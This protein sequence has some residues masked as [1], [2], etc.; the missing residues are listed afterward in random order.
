MKSESRKNLT[1]NNF[2]K[3]LN[4]NYSQIS[5]ES[6]YQSQNY[7]KLLSSQI[8]STNLS[9]KNFLNISNKK[10]KK[11]GMFD[12]LN[13]I[14]EEIE[15]IAYDLD[16]V[17]RKNSD[18]D[19]AQLLNMIE[20]DIININNIISQN[21]LS[22]D[23]DKIITFFDIICFILKKNHKKFIENEL[24][25]IYFL[26]IEKLLALFKPLDIN[27]NDMMSKLVGHIKYEKKA[28]DN[29]L[30]KEGD[31]GDK[32]YIILKGEVGILIHQERMVNCTLRDF[33]KCLMILYLYQEKSLV[34]KIILNNRELLKFDDRCFLTLM[35]T[36]KFYHFFKD[37]TYLKKTYKD[38]LEF[39]Q[40]ETKIAKYIYKK[41]D[42][43]PMN[44]FSTLDL[45]N[46]L[47]EL[48]YEFY[49]RIINR[50]QNIFFTEIEN[51]DLNI[52][53]SRNNLINNPT[54]LSE[55]GLYTRA[56]QFIEN[57]YKTDDFLDKISSIQEISINY[58]YSCNVHNYIERISF[59]VLMDIIVND[60][61][62]YYNKIYEDKKNFK[63]YNYL[64]VNRL[65]DGNIFGELALINPS[66]K[67]TATVIINEDCHLGV[68][69]KE[70]YDLSIKTAQEKLRAR[71]VKFFLEGHI[72][73][74]MSTNNFL[75]N[76]FFRFKKRIFNSG[77]TLFHRGEKR[78]KIFFIYRGEL[79]LNAKLSLKKV[80]EI[81]EYLSEEKGSDDGGLS[82]IYL[83]E[84]FHFKKFYQEVKKHFRVYVLKDKEISGLDDMTQNNIYLFDCVCV[85]SEQTEV[86][87][88]DYKIFEK[89]LQ[90]SRNIRDNNKEYV[91]MK[92]KILINRLY[93]QRDSIAINEYN[94]I[95]AYSLNYNNIENI[96]KNEEKKISENNI[97][98]LNNVFSLKKRFIPFIEESQIT[99]NIN[100]S[101]NTN[102][103]K[104][105]SII[106]Q[107][108]DL[109]VYLEL[110][111]KNKNQNKISKTDINE[112]NNLF[113]LKK[114]QTPIKLK[115]LNMKKDKSNII[116][117]I[118]RERL[119]GFDNDIYLPKFEKNKKISRIGSSVKDNFKNERISSI[120][121]NQKLI[122]PLPKK[123]LSSIRKLKKCITSS[124]NVLMKE[125]KKRYIEPIR[126]PFPKR[127]FV[128]DNQK[129]FEPLLSGNPNISN[130]INITNRDKSNRSNKTIKSN[131]SDRSHKSDKK[132]KYED[133][134]IQISINYVQKDENNKDYIIKPKLLK[135]RSDV[136]FENS[137]SSNRNRKDN[138][139][140]GRNKINNYS[141]G[142]NGINGYI[143]KSIQEKYK[144][145]FLIDC[146]CLDKWEEKENKHLEK[147]SGILR[148]KKIK[149][150]NLKYNINKNIFK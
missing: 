100:N 108:K 131:K 15:K 123:I 41:N 56:H 50:M 147:E 1:L 68:L 32:F 105:L 99:N 11:I 97:K 55:L 143:D 34:L 91:S 109:N 94:R 111:K 73:K 79:R 8:P 59:E 146:L 98:A 132:K 17:N 92:K 3:K 19:N 7:S 130:R 10:V 49:C 22:R 42:F 93:K 138:L 103:N 84:N 18:I 95:K 40:V 53:K 5:S 39:I 60:S 25:K 81:I 66:K 71:N 104:R 69:N 30:F 122:S 65:K 150:K 90:D 145:I 120:R 87:E 48:L 57:K 106:K 107:T 133:K 101:S 9:K 115:E 64:E 45:Q 85:S 125:F 114:N 27:L 63:F 116:L 129:I 113:S 47:A 82:K 38:I 86:Y 58:I 137:E 51:A 127:R 14:D 12:F 67:R 110:N 134:S 23:N 141:F 96:L 78:T 128:F 21:N 46:S 89:A 44:T 144:D 135:S 136:Q 43:S 36:L 139:S 31:K 140:S 112:I 6:N 118:K 76:Y 37:F 20:G 88:L 119:L 70:V 62:D 26:R 28:K 117:P 121:K 16:L 77:Q 72:F 24:L 61:N 4:K 35:D 126:T 75:N 54:N 13:P 74:N 124:S 29:I 2:N 102:Q 83:K 80:T 33:L 148:G 149:N 142:I 52:S